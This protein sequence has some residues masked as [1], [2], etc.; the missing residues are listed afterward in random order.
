MKSKIRTFF[1]MVL[2]YAQRNFDPALRCE[3]GMRNWDSNRNMPEWSECDYRAWWVW[4]TIDT[5][6][7]VPS[8]FLCAFNGHKYVDE[9]YAGPESG[10]IDLV[11]TR[12]GW[13]PGRVYLY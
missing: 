3:Y 12:C 13:S 10:C 4:A 1:A 9:G 5:L 2:G 8:L 7:L 11:C 6:A